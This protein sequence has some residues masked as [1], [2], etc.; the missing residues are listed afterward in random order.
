M[1]REPH[2]ERPYADPLELTLRLRPLLPHLGNVCLA[3]ACAMSGEEVYQALRPA[4]ISPKCIRAPTMGAHFL[5]RSLSIRGREPQGLPLRGLH[6][7]YL[8][9][10]SLTPPSTG[11]IAPVVLAERLDARN[12]TVSATSSAKTRAFS[13]L[14]CR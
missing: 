10:A 8:G 2:Q 7:A 12:S 13:R 4:L 14:R 11:I 1:K 9:N 3:L 6:F 5:A